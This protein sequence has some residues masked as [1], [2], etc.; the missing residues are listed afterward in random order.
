MKRLLSL[1]MTAIVSLMI[2]APLSLAQHMHGPTKGEPMKM[3]S[4]EVLVEGVKVVFQIMVNKEH[5]KMLAD[6]KMEETPEAGTTHNI[7]VLLFDEKSQ[8]E[9]TDAVVRMKV[10]DPSG[11]EQIK[12]LKAEKAMK[13]QDAYFNLP[14]KG[15]YQVMILFNIGNQKRTAGIYY[16]LK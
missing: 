9:I 1:L 16:E 10:V 4:K 14:E 5:K 13:S 12:T 11:K 2:L 7:T 15:R 8:R 3:D 6:M